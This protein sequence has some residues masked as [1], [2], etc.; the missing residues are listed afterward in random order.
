M[1]EEPGLGLHHF[2]FQGPAGTTSR[3][4]DMTVVF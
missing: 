2:W 1:P 3:S 4:E